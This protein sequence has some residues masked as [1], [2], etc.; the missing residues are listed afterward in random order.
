VNSLLVIHIK[1][2]V[3]VIHRLFL[4]CLFAVKYFA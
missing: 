3:F 4:Y 1:L 2:I